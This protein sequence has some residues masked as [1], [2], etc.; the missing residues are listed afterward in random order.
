MA[1]VCSRRLAHALVVATHRHRGT[2]G[3]IPQNFISTMRE[4]I[5]VH[6]RFIGVLATAA[7]LGVAV[8]G[9]SNPAGSTAASTCEAPPAGNIAETSF[10]ENWCLPTPLPPTTV[11][12]TCETD[13][14]VIHI[15]PVD[16]V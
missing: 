11:D 6:K 3:P 8:V 16:K 15:N 12:Q 10:Q 13:Y 4:G 9:F 5:I 7:A 2:G 14:G 1:S